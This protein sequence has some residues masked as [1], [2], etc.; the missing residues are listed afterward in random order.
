MSSSR[1]RRLKIQ[2]LFNLNVTLCYIVSHCVTLCHIVLMNIII[3]VTK[4]WR[5]TIWLFCLIIDLPAI[6]P[7]QT[8][9]FCMTIFRPGNHHIRVIPRVKVNTK[10]QKLLGRQRENTVLGKFQKRLLDLCTQ[11]K[12]RMVIACETCNHRTVI[13]C[14]RTVVQGKNILFLMPTVF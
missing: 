3:D 7:E 1:L 10:M 6:P 9:P 12:N 8:C 11:R 4:W 2:A 13:N 5:Y 14:N